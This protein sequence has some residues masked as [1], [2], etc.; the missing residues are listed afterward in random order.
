MGAFA[1]F[2]LS[3]PAAERQGGAW[4]E[5]DARTPGFW[6]TEWDRWVW[7][8]P[9]LHEGPGSP[10]R[11]DRVWRQRPLADS[12]GG[13]AGARETALSRSLPNVRQSVN[14]HVFVSHR[15]GRA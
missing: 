1:V 10:S 9:V 4:A 5:R 6:G 14:T 13:R 12:S 2:V 8:C 7:E 11:V 15:G 3:P